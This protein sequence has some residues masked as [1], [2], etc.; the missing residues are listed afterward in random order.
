MKKEH[1]AQALGEKISHRILIIEDEHAIA[2]IIDMNLKVAGY[3]T[4]I[5]TIP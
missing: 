1:K 3:T 2:K 5:L 4:T